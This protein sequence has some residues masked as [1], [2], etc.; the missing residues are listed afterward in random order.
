M[1]G[2]LKGKMVAPIVGLLVLMVGLIV[3]YVSV[4]TASLVERFD[5]ER[6]AAATQ[7]IR[8]YLVAHE[9]KTLMATVAMGG[10][11][12]LIS[13]I[14]SGERMGIWQYVFDSK[15]FMG[16]NEIIIASHEGITLARSHM[17][18]S[19]GDNVS[20]VPSIAA[21]L[22]R[23]VLTLYTPTPTAAMVM[24]TA[25]P[26]LD[27]DELLG[28]VV[29]N[30]VIGSND[31]VDR[32]K[33]T[34]GADITV[35]AGD[36]SVA[37]SLIHPETNARAVGT[38]V[39]PHV[40][41]MVL[42]RGES[43]ALDLDVFGLL[44]YSAY[45]FP[46]HG[47]DGRPSGMVFVGISKEYATNITNA[48]LR[49][50]IFICLA[51]LAVVALLMLMLIMRTLKP[52]GL[53]TSTLNDAARGDLTQRLPEEGRDEIATASRSFNQTMEELGKMITAIK[54][55]AGS[56][57]KIGED[58]ASNMT[59]TASASNQI[60]ASV[61]SIKSRAIGQSASVTETNAT[62]ESVTQNID[63]L[64]GQVERQSGAVSHAASAIEQMIANIRS[65]TEI[66]EKNAANVKELQVSSGAGKA[67]LQDVATDIQGIAR[68]SE[69][70]LE[71]NSVMENIASQTNLLSMN[72]AIEAAHAGDA[73]KGFAVVAA[74]IR[75]LAE[76]SGE[77]SKTI[78]AALKK[79][80][81]SIEKITRSTGNVLDK[82]ETIDQSVRKV[83]EQ[84]EVIRTAM[85]EQ[86]HGSKQ[87]LSA[88][89]Q[90]AE[91][92]QQVKGG[93]QQMLEGSKEVI[94]EGRNLEKV[95]QEITGGINEIASGAEQV[96]RAVSAVSELS[97]RT[98]DNISSLAQAVSKFK[99]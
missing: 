11:A 21:G 6:M 19:Y 73:G 2:S 31:F 53:L 95:T 10:S 48:L 42:E 78:S 84:E 64:S 32:L 33:G 87:V 5:D 9:Q 7:A 72:A 66:L 54:Q 30:F 26:I 8:A 37:S 58:L 60:S 93:S 20:G 83:A 94:A 24:T 69:G 85:E 55:K 41:A 15:T 47:A 18:D 13:R 43:L 57:S 67:S 77:Q 45:Y 92:T 44:P 25:A 3:A 16:V 79:I 90:V 34:F 97:G 99:V 4:T 28:S 86:S 91:I 68:E 36:T 65:V 63:R 75:K 96:N 38:A 56:L 70:L 51:G 59:E 71:I 76:S 52:I 49:N 81:E 61:Q 98:Q 40:A 29:V 50:L 82:F 74:E 80:K 35:F 46:L 62:M 17:R 14:R 22:R 39:A 27:G 1:F 12:E 23:E 88:S 89:G